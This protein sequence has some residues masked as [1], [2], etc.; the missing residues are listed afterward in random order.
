MCILFNINIIII[1][2]ILIKRILIHFGCGQLIVLLRGCFVAIP[3]YLQI[4]ACIIITY[5]FH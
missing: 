2:G 3:N 5:L 4:K 1:T